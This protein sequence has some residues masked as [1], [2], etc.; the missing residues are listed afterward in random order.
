MVEYRLA[1]IQDLEQI[2]AMNIADNPSDD[3]W[4][5]WR[6]QYIGYNREGKAET[7]VVVIDGRPVG[8]GTLLYSSKCSAIR[9]R[10]VLADGQRIANVNALRIIKEYEG[11]GHVSKLCK[12]MEQRARQRGYNQITI[13]VE[14]CE[15]RNRAIYEHWGYTE[16][17]LTEFEDGETVLYYGKNI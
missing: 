11:Q 3:R 7:F 13:G 8:E 9:G 1:T 17:V 14:E 12:L 16:L 2:W 10:T 6:D 15:L 4:I 5:K